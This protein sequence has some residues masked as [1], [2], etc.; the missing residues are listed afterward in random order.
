MKKL[1]TFVTILLLAIAVSAPAQDFTL[2]DFYG[3]NPNL[4]RIV[5]SI[6]RSLTPHER[7]AQLIVTST[8]KL[9]KPIEH[10]QELVS[11]KTVG[12]VLFLSGSPQVFKTQIEHLQ[13]IHQNWPLL[14]SID[15]EPSL[16]NRRLQ[17]TPTMKPTAQIQSPNEAAEAAQLIADI[18]REIGFEVNYAPVVDLSPNNEAIGNRTFGSDSASVVSK[19]MAFIRST[20]QNQIVA[21]AKHFPGHGRVEGDTHKKLVYINGKLTEVNIYKPLIKNGVVSI[22]VGHIAVENNE[23]YSTNGKPATL[24]GK[25]VTD[26]LRNQLGFEGIII[27]DALN[28]GAVSEIENCGLEAVKAGCDMV[29][30]PIDERATHAQILHAYSNDRELADQ[31]DQSVKRILRLKVC[32]KTFDI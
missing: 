11:E 16:L 14:M 12:G 7:V 28:M 6:H 29:L 17:G 21:T 5:D 25:I 15:A 10:V 4:E 8:G 18:L 2:E 19:A 26:L 32:L 24:S 30:M 31:I 3:N 27:T 23:H 20:Q 1:K 22:M 13:S 9:G